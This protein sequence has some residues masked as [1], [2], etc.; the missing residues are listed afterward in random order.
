AG[1]GVS[2]DTIARLDAA[3]RAFFALPER[4]KMKIAMARGG[5]AWRG[6][7]P[8]GGE[9]TSG[10]PDLK[11]GVYF[12][13]ELGADDSRVKA[14]LPMHGANL[15]PEAA[16]ELRP[17]VLD[18]MSE[19]TRAAH[20][21]MRGVALSLSLDEDYF[22][23]TYTAEPTV[24]F[25]MFHYPPARAV[26]GEWGVGE[27]TDYGLLT[28]LAQDDCGGLQVKARDGWIEAPPIAGTLVCNIG[29]MLDRLTGGFYRSTPHRVRNVSGRERLS[30]PLFF[31]PAF[32]AVIEPLPARATHARD[33]SGERWDRANVHVFQGTYGDYLLGKVGKVFPDLGREVL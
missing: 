17:A 11:E 18:F 5:R 26:D 31:D 32:D 33:D 1:H 6:F 7:F 4:E 23:R 9:L 21:V 10:R 20:A 22:A 12:G 14:G 19:T 15:W 27:H 29:D 2:P 8:V 25:R 30:F 13:T 3:A 24:L 16:P 28:L